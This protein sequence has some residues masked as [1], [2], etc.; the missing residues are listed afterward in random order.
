MFHWKINRP[1]KSNQHG[2]W[3]KTKQK[4]LIPWKWCKIYKNSHKRFA[5]CVKIGCFAFV[6]RSEI[7]ERPLHKM[8]TTKNCSFFRAFVRILTY[9]YWYFC[10]VS[11]FLWAHCSFARSSIRRQEKYEIMNESRYTV[12]NP[13]IIDVWECNQNS[14]LQNYSHNRGSTKRT[15]TNNR[16]ITVERHLR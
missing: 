9:Y 16:E 11:S 8:I 2:S 10:F 3:M 1:K 15:L 14:T 7:W 13:I 6:R 5:K 12:R 4:R